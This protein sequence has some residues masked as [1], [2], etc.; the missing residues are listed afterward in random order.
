MA[1]SRYDAQRT[2]ALSVFAP[3]YTLRNSAATAERTSNVSDSIT[4]NVAGVPVSTAHFIDGKRV[5]STRTFE[6][7]SPIDRSHFADVSAGGPEEIDAAARRAFPAW[8]ALVP[9]AARR[10]YKGSPRGW[11]RRSAALA[12]PALDA[13]AASGAWTSIA[14]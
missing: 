13:K 6:D 12:I 3:L 9:R 8:A 1:F 14:T 11:P 7:R 5:A 2:R 4:T 10:F